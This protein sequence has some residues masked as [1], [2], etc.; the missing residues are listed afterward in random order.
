MATLR[1]VSM[2]TCACF[3]HAY[4]QNFMEDMYVN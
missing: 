1:A 2:Q 3:L 4:T